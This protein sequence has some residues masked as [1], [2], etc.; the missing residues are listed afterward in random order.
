MASDSPVMKP[1]LAA[2]PYPTANLT[3]K[4]NPGT[5]LAQAEET[6]ENGLRTLCTSGGLTHGIPP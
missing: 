3:A 4:M 5:R 1:L 2:L 6:V